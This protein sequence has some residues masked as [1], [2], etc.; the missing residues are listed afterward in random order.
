MSAPLPPSSRVY[1]LDAARAVMLL[2]GIPFHVSE[3]YRVSNGYS[4]DSPDASYLASAISAAVHVFRMPAFFILS[5]FFAAMLLQKGT[6][7]SWMK[8]RTWK[9]GIPLVAT[10][11][12]LGWFENS[13]ALYH[14]DGISWSS[15]WAL[16][17]DAPISEWVHHRWFLV[18]LLMYCGTFALLHPRLAVSAAASQDRSGNSLIAKVGILVGL[19]LAPFLAIVAGKVA[20]EWFWIAPTLKQYANLYVKYLPFFAIGYWTFSTRRSFEGLL[21]IKRWELPIA[22]LALLSYFVTY[23]AFY[24]DGPSGSSAVDR[25]FTL[26]RIS[27]ECLAG[28]YAA[29]FFYVAMRLILN[30]R[31]RTVSYFVEASFCIYLVHEVFLLAF[32][33][34]LLDIG[35]DPYIEMALICGGTVIGSV[36]V[37][38]IVR[39]STL[40]SV[41]F[42][43]G[44]VPKL[45]P[46]GNQGLGAAE[47]KA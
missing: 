31:S 41:L 24:P 44:P 3:I 1:F 9:L 23:F 15:A 39:R 30:R 16:A 5:G 36:V 29:K 35:L 47:A 33:G 21:H 19:M 27:V 11:L 32:G 6:P 28:F 42:N 7:E 45:R 2:L 34:A 40:L 43:G 8:G 17:T 12:L 20:G 13:I 14:Q 37:F 38:E 22:A 46:A 26:V 4:I 10:T 18:T 25:I